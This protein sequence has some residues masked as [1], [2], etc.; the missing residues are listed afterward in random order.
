MPVQ[1]LGVNKDLFLWGVYLGAELLGHTVTP[2]FTFQGIIAVLSS[3]M[4]AVA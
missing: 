2:C 3:Q 4:T 1:V